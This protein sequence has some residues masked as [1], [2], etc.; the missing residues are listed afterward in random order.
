V[1]R[2]RVVLFS[3]YSPDLGGGGTNLRTLIPRLDNVDVEWLY[4]APGTAKEPRTVRL[5][6]PLSGGPV[7]TDLA[8]T[9]A[10]W[11]G[12]QTPAFRRIVAALTSRGAQRYWIVGHVEGALVA[13]ALAA[14][15][16]RV[17]LSIQ[18]DVPDGVFAR[19]QRYRPLAGFVRPAFESTLRRVASIDVTS[20][21]MQRYYEER[22]GVSSVVVHPFVGALPAA[23]SRPALAGELRLGHIGSIYSTD[24]WRALLRALQVVSAERGLAPKM[25]MIGLAAKYRP[26]ADEFPGCVE[27][28][29]DLPE[30]EAVERLFTCH[31]VYAMYPFD[32]RS[33]VFRRTSLPTKLTS[34]IKAQRPILAHSP[35]GSTLLDIVERYRLGIACTASGGRDVEAAL[36]AALAHDASASAFERARDEVYGDG[37]AARLSACLQAL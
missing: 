7:W 10:L 8:R 17:H 4:T 2:A 33:D 25:L 22:L 23:P 37:N 30:A 34:Y 12:V 14:S 28:V 15:G 36:R 29:S 31:V 13:R 18:D 16:A 21:G 35:A 26:I 19:S 27:L 11:G 32:A 3:P 20:D 24:E 5:G 6:A 9:V 1:S